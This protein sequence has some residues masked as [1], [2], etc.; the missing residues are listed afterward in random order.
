MQDCMVRLCLIFWE[1]VELSSKVSVQFC[2]P[3]RNEWEFLL[4]HILVNIWCC[5]HSRLLQHSKKYVMVAHWGK[6]NCGTLITS[7]FPGSLA[8]KI[9]ACNVGDPGL[10]PVLGR[11]SGEGISYPLQYSWASLVAQM[12]KNLAAMQETW[13]WSLGWEDPLENGMATHSSIPAW[14]IPMDSRAWWATVHGLQRV[15]HDWESKH[16]TV[17][18]VWH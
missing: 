14:R 17:T 5:H 18:C 4:P 1:T 8:G 9:S 16:S 10:I 11:S 3:I 2:I 7:D 13:V 12:V 15:R 6:K